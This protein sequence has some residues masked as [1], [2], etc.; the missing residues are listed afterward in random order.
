MIVR[1]LDERGALEALHVAVNGRTVRN[2]RRAATDDM[3]TGCQRQ[4][5]ET[6]VSHSQRHYKT[7]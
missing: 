3:L 7:G 2:A 4:D 5:R 1:A 6:C